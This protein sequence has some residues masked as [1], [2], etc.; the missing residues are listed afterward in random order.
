MK[1]KFRAT[2]SEK[3]GELIGTVESSGHQAFALEC[4]VEIVRSISNSTGVHVDEVV[5]DMRGLLK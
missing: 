4:L 3:G 2:F 5:T 1:N